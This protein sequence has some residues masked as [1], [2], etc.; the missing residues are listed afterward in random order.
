MHQ[1]AD[2]P[3]KRSSNFEHGNETPRRHRDRRADDGK[4]E[5]KSITKKLL[6]CSR[7]TLICNQIYREQR[8][9]GQADVDVGVF[10]APVAHHVDL[11]HRQVLLGPREIGEQP[12]N[13]RW[14]AVSIFAAQHNNYFHN[15]KLKWSKIINFLMIF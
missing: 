3:A 2:A 1:F 5:L 6:L 9:P 14:M 4:N 10:G 15:K 8:E 12:C 13:L 11:L 7:A